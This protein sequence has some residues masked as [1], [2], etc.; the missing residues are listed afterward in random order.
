MRTSLVNVLSTVPFL[1]IQNT[2]I[3]RLIGQLLD[4]FRIEEACQVS[5]EYG[6]VTQDVVVIQVM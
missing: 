2:A 1:Q 6:H 4:E 3:C 5:L